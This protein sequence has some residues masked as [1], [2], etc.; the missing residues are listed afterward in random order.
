MNIKAV[1]CGNFWFF[2]IINSAIIHWN[3]NGAASS[4]IWN[5][6]ASQTAHLHRY[7]LFCF[8]EIVHVDTTN[9]NNDVSFPTTDSNIRF[10]KQHIKKLMGTRN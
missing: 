4:M 9:R 6:C 3:M 5:Q 7:A 2:V 8:E 10:R 1:V